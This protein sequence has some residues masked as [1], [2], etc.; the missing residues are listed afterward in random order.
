MKVLA[1]VL[2]LT[3]LS[4]GV[5]SPN[6]TS[7]ANVDVTPTQG[8]TTKSH[9]DSETTTAPKKSLTTSAASE[10]S[11][12]NAHS[13]VHPTSDK[14]LPHILKKLSSRW[15]TDDEDIFKH[16]KP[17]LDPKDML[18]QEIDALDEITSNSKVKIFKTL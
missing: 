5:V 2:L 15:R 4:A 12:S 6:E 17:F 13:T 8:P 18:L 14:T 3:V 11:N 16:V 1:A 9:G 10:E 7:P